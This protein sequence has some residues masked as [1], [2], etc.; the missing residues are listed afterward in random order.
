MSLKIDY[1][2]HQ[3]ICKGVKPGDKIGIAIAL[4]D[5]KYLGCIFACFE[6]GLKIVILLKPLNKDQIYQPKYN[7][8]FPL[9]VLIVDIED[10][11]P[12]FSMS[13]FKNNSKLV[14]RIKDCNFN[15]IK[16]HN[17]SPNIADVCLLCTSSGSTGNPKKIEHTHEFFY[18]LC[19]VNW[20]SL[21]F[22][23][24]DN[25]LH[26]YSFQHG[27][28]L[29]I[30]FLP[31]LYACKNHYFYCGVNVESD[32]GWDDLISFCI[33]NNI[34]KMHSIYATETENIISAIRRSDKGLPD[35]TI[36]VL[37][38]INPEWIS[39]IKEG[40]LKKII[41]VFGT[42]E[43]SGP[44]FLSYVDQNTKHFDPRFFN[45]PIEDFY[46][47][48][49]DEQ[50]GLTVNIPI[51]DKT[52]KTEDYFHRD[53][54]GYR[55]LSKNKLYRLSDI[56]INISD[57][58][59]IFQN[60]FDKIIMDDIIIIVDEIHSKLYSVTSN[61]EVLIYIDQIKKDIEIFYDR[62]IVLNGCFYIENLK[63]F[64]VGIKP[65]RE[66]LLDYIR[67]MEKKH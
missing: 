30:Y 1:W 63:D 18:N 52:I 38:F 57:L 5:D 7:A 2:K 8:H 65:D 34:T 46:K 6:L 47:I 31:S 49:L 35:L 59:K 21:G 33:E 48:S 43:S 50:G 20:K 64:A 56:D 4:M 23:E 16:I 51:Y 27:S 44:L 10:F 28:A 45:H 9:D 15:D 25:V 61:K 40:K 14:I 22:Q 26:S 55:F 29:G 19:S 42:S 36:M 60:N 17:F 24:N 13:F 53:S 66:K 67:Q 41:S 37:S 62:K 12:E 58:Q 54:S 11:I 39:I 32:K 3:L